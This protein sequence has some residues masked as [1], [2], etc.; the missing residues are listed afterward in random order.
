MQATLSVPSG[1]ASVGAARSAGGYI[2]SPPV[3]WLCLILA[4]FLAFGL[5]EL[6]GHI[7]W[8][9]EGARLFGTPR[10][11]VEF[12]GAVWIYGHLFAVVFRS[13]ANPEIFR[14][15]RLRFTAVP[16]GL[17]VLLALSE[18]AL[19]SGIFLAAVWDVYHSAMQNFGLCRIYDARA[20]N[21]RR[22]GRR[23]DVGI[24]LCLYVVPILAGASLVPTL[25]DL[26]GFRA[27]GWE[28]PGRALAWIGE[29]ALPIRITALAAGAAYTL[30]YALAIARLRARGYVLPVPKAALLA[31][32]GVGSILIWNFLPPLEAFFAANFFHGLQY[33]AF[34]W[35]IEGENLGRRVGLPRTGPGRL[36]TF[37]LFA[38]SI[39]AAGIAYERIQPGDWRW[40]VPVPV[41]VSLM[42]YW[43][44]GFVWSVQRGEV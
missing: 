35:R 4:P 5:V 33:Y 7:G 41:L 6:S 19:V 44:D 16:V 9:H 14:R 28:T 40:I 42:H 8:L 20:G 37:A 39:A 24:N 31:S 10:T 12:F 32:V 29:H 11:R 21:D 1:F 26:E 36:A 27:L 23:L 18:A 34:V 15:H 3:D 17:F 22:L 2:A 30:F 25:I 38:A 13:H 43:Y